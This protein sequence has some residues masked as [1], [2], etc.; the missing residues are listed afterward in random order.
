M[1]GPPVIYRP[2]GRYW[3]AWQKRYFP[4]SIK[5]SEYDPRRLAEPPGRYRSRLGG[6]Q[7][8]VRLDEADPFGW[9]ALSRAHLLRSEHEAAI[10]ASDT[11]ITLNP[12]FSLAHF[13]RAHA[14]WHAGRPGEAIASHDEAL[15]LSPLDPMIWAYLASKA[16]ALVLLGRFEEAVALSQRSQ[17]QANSAIFS[18]LAEISAL[19]HLGRGADAREAMSRARKKKPDLSI[20]YV[21][22]TLPIT[23]P[24]CREV[25]LEGLRMAGVPE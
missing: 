23:D 3:V 11:A 13:G 1:P 15:R 10:A 9:V 5:T 24:R 22:Q 7:T 14:L 19:G 8:A 18:H 2:S 4:N 21:D 6:R 25:F 16:I 12:N 20:A 17:Q